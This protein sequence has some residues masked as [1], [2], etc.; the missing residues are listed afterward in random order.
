MPQAKTEEVFVFAGA[1]LGHDPEGCSEWAY[2][3][4]ERIVHPRR[5]GSLKIRL[6]ACRR[7]MERLVR[8][9]FVSHNNISISYEFLFWLTFAS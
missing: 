6:D 9:I 4:A 7:R 2:Y 8:R 5:D 1:R 3:F